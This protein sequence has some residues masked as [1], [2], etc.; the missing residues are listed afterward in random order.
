MAIPFGNYGWFGNFLT[1][2]IS[3]FRSE[4][5]RC[6]CTES[7]TPL[8]N[9]VCVLVDV[10]RCGIAFLRSSLVRRGCPQDWGGLQMSILQYYLF[11]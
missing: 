4:G 2:N 3:Y 10:P 11:F 8:H 7:T 6:A 5:K 9:N 1:I